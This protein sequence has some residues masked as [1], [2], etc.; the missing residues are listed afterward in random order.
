MHNLFLFLL[1]FAFGLGYFAL[2]TWRKRNSANLR[3]KRDGFRPG[4]G[5][6][7]LDGM[8]SLSLLLD[9]RSKNYVWAEEIEIFLTDLVANDQTT[10]AT[11]RQTQKIRQM[12]R[13]GDMLPISLC[14]AI[15]KAAGDPQRKYSCVM[16]SVLRYKIGEEKFEMKMD[17]F[18]VNMMGLT[19]ASVHRERKLVPSFPAPVQSTEEPQVAHAIAAKMK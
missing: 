5:F 19:A 3:D 2:R 6:T 13:R 18:R 17:N 11:F 14:E 15:Y 4:I 7:R 16:S 1:T 10:D 9:N 12:V 8:A